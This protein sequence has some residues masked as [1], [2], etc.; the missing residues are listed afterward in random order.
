MSEPDA[1][2]VKEGIRSVICDWLTRNGYP[3]H[4]EQGT[5][6]IDWLRGEIN[7]LLAEP[8]IDGRSSPHTA[9]NR[10]LLAVADRLDVAR[11]LD[12]SGA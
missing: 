7:A 10:A 11:H 2:R 1:Q 8:Q 9:W 3:V 4:S 12:E 6:P 5:V